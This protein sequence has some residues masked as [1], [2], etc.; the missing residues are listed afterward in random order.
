[1]LIQLFSLRSVF[2]G[3]CGERPDVCGWSLHAGECEFSFEQ[4]NI[5]NVSQYPH[6]SVPSP[7]CLYAQNNLKPKYGLEMRGSEMMEA[8]D[9][10]EL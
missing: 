6:S 1:M 4:V 2:W 8:K 5:L 9:N 10:T 3:I 7:S